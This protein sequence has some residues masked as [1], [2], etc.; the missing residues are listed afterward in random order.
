P[1]W[2]LDPELATTAG[3]LAAAPALECHLEGWTRTQNAMA[4]ASLL[5]GAGVESG[6]VED[7]ADVHTDPQL[8]H[9]RHFRPVTHPVLGTHPAETHAIRFSETSP[10]LRS[11]APK[12]GQHTDHVLCNLLGMPADEVARL[13]AAGVLE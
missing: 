6:P 10:E 3:R 11:P 12:L 1:E 13:R 5:Q 9:R 8:V 7:L 2:A 4:V